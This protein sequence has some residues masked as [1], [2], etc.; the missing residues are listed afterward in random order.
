MR[1]SLPASVFVEDRKI[2]SEFQWNTD[3]LETEGT[4]S[5][6]VDYDRKA[7]MILV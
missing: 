4:I 3:M 1:N 7:N 5:V 2:W 6:A